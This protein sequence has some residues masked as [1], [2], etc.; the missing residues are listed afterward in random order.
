[1][2]R[3]SISLVLV[4]FLALPAVSRADGKYALVVGVEKYIPTELP[5]LDYAEDDAQALGGALE[6]L[7]FSVIAMTS[8]SD[9]PRHRSTTAARIIEQVEARL[10]DREPSDTIVL[11]FSGHGLQF[12]GDR[13]FYFCPGEAEL[14]DRTTLVPMSRV[15]EAVGRC[16]AGRK[17]LLVDACRGELTPEAAGK[18]VAIELDPA[19]VFRAEPPTGTVA[20]FSCQ[21]REKSYELK[22]FGHSVFTYHVVEYLTGA[23]AADR[24]PRREVSVEELVPFVRNRTRETTAKKL[25]ATQKPEALAPDARIPDWPLGRLGDLASVDRQPAMDRSLPTV[26]PGDREPGKIVE[27]S[28]GMV[29]VAIPAGEFDMGSDDFED[30]A[31]V[32]RVRI[33]KPFWMGKTEVTLGQFMVFYSAGPQGRL[34]SEKPRHLSAGYDPITR[35]FVHKRE[36]L[37]WAWGHPGMQ[38]IRSDLGKRKAYSY[39]VVNVTWNECVA[40]CDWL[41]RKEGK[42]Y[43][44]PTEAEW[45]YACRAGTKT[46]YWTGDDPESLAAHENLLDAAAAGEFPDRRRYAISGTDGHAFTAPAGSTGQTNPFGL[47]DMHGNVREWCRD[48]YD[49]GFYANAPTADP[50][51]PS[52]EGLYR[53]IRGGS[54]LDGPALCRSANRNRLQKPANETYFPEYAITVGFRVVCESE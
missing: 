53:V 39:P 34:T 48:W 40:F 29:L 7:G 41:S 32:H 31:P 2:S 3:L 12:K 38:D 5:S 16:R 14:R 23:A 13:E 9:N 1:M 36:N 45:E 8:V 44:L 26:P 19:G 46:R 52:N 49:A 10:D 37:P 33:T 30:E 4:A 25:G 22:Q 6:R 50:T 54:W 27:N 51:G 20:L 24:Y 17:L 35:R 21:P 15:L 18:G 28:L 42:R 43:R 47:A 11:A